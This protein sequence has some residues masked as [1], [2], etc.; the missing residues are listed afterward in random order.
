MLRALL[1]MYT[2]IL[3]KVIGR[4]KKDN[5]FKD[6]NNCFNFFIFSTIYTCK[7]LIKK[8]NIN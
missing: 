7:I 6:K 2:S 4:S 3:Y 8:F 5:F 1:P